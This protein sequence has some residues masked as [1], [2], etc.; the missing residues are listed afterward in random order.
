MEP[1]YF[2]ARRNKQ[3]KQTY[4]QRQPQIIMVDLKS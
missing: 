4:H 1:E 3:K 2:L